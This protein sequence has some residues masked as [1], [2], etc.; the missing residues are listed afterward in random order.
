LEPPD[1]AVDDLKGRVLA[2]RDRLRLLPNTAPAAGPPDPETGEAWDR[3]HVLGHLDEMLPYWTRQ[4]RRAVLRG[5]PIGRDD[6]ARRRRQDAVDRSHA[7]GEAA[8]RKS[9]DVGCGRLLALLDRLH[10]AE[11]PKELLTVDGQRITLRQALESRLVG[12]LEQHLDQLS[13]MG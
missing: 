10:D 4:V 11:L 3:V 1:P 5:D 7:R 2:A 6:A 12:H 9:V 13:A 8:L